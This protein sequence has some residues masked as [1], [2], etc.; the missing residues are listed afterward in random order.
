[1]G[2]SCFYTILLRCSFLLIGLSVMFSVASAD[3]E[4]PGRVWHV[5]M[6]CAERDFPSIGDAL[7]QAKPKDTILVYWEPAFPYYME[8]LVIDKP[9]R[10]ISNAA[11]ADITSYDYYPVIA[12]VSNEIVHITVPGVELI[13]F[14]L[15]YL[16]K[17]ADC[18]D[19]ALCY[20]ESIGLRLDA[21]ALIRQVAITNCSTGIL[22]AYTKPYLGQ[23]STIQLCR[24]GLPPDHGL[25]QTGFMQTKNHYGIVLLGCRQEGQYL[26]V[27]R[28]KI[29]DCQIMRNAQYGLV[30]TTANEPEMLGNLIEL[31]GKGPFRI[32][33]P[34]LGEN[35]KLI[36][37]DKLEGS[38]K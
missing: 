15:I 35:Q 24:I 27:G 29:S 32:V 33:N 22:T 12:S 3:D 30:Y 8:H 38:E 37:F 17:P 1:M 11:A 13:G 34:K 20:A 28:D 7:R 36:W 26:G 19:E 14:N 21:P 31:N 23:A 10:I 5:C 4:A 16:Q 6:E 25:T 2:K 9:V 18:E